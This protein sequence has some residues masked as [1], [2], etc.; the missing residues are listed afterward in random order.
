MG[1]NLKIIADMQAAV[2][3]LQLAHLDDFV[4]TLRNFKTLLAEG[5]SDL[6]EFFVPSEAFKQ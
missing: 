2:G 3:V 6:E 5:L 1:F 4:A